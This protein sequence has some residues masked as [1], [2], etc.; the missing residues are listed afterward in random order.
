M[1]IQEKPLKH[2]I[3]NFYGYGSWQARFWFVSY[4]DGGGDLPEEVAE[5]LL[6][7]NN[8]HP[9]SIEP[10][11]CDIRDLYKHASIFWDGPKADQFKNLYEYRFGN[12]AISNGVWKNLI[13]FIH[14]YRGDALP[15]LLA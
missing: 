1:V 7:F 4:E 5:K 11:L 9:S 12:E 2:W 3:D 15:D 10:T 6:Y 14:G 13:A 8:T